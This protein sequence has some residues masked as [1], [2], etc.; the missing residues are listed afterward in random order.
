MQPSDF[1]FLVSAAGVRGDLRGTGAGKDP[2]WNGVWSSAV[3]RQGT[4]NNPAD[5]DQG[6]VVEIAIP[7]T[8]IGVLPLSGSYL[9]LDLAVD[10]SDPGAPRAF[11]TF[12]WA[13]IA[14]GSYAQPRRWKTVLLSP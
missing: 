12:D 14:P 7:W 3:V 11:S 6:Y 9:G 1:Q 8:T 4:L 2:G 13:G 10:D 5:T